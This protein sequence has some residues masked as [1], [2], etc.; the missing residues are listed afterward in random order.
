MDKLQSSTMPAA[1]SDNQKLQ[2]LGF[3]QTYSEAALNK[4]YEVAGTVYNTT[5]GYVPAAIE[6]KVSWGEGKVSE[7]STQYGA[8]IVNSV[9]DKSQQFLG[10][11][12]SQ[13]D[14]V[15]KT[16]TNFYEK[17]SGFLKSHSEFHSK[18]L[19]HFKEARDAYIQQA[20]DAIAFLKEHGAKGTAQHAIEQLTTA[21]DNL[22]QWVPKFVGDQTNFLLEKVTQAWD[23][24]YNMP[25][26]QKTLEKL[27]P[28]VELAKKKYIEAHDAVVQAPS[29]DKAF[30]AAS[31]GISKAQ[32]SYPYKTA[33]NKLY[34]LVS[35]VADPVLEKASPYVNNVL[36]HIKPQHTASS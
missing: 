29:Y 11:M 23:S 21:L 33:A 32:E 6:D 7:I 15:A 14:S 18:N 9:Q 26:V 30:N 28:S 16:A 25:T 2:R 20:K 35:P 1:E 31:T 17:N 12:D 4:G 8:P 27:S 13:V 24:L 19:E 10:I 34:P 36:E 3:V 5:R 22:K